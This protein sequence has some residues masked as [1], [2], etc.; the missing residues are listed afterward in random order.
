MVEVCALFCGSGC[1]G[2][3]AKLTADLVLGAPQFMNP[4]G[5]RE[6]DLR[7][8]CPGGCGERAERGRDCQGA[9]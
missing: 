7:G 5:D 8:A 3:M 9:R 2:A 4:L 1:G 6:I